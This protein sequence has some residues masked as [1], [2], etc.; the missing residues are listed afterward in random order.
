MTAP[1]RVAIVHERFTDIGGSEKVVEQFHQI[2]P[3][4]VVHA[5]I[6]DRSVLPPGLVDADIRTSSLRRI[7]RGGTS[8]AHLLPLLPLAMRQLDLGPV[9]LVV[10]SHH[11]FANRVR[12]DPS[13]PIVSYVHSP[14]RWLWDARFRAMEAGNRV[15]RLALDAFA[16][17]QRRFDHAAAQRVHTLIANSTHVAN[18]IER[19]W[20]RTSHVVAPPIDTD[21]FHADPTIEREEFFLAAGRLVQYKAVDVAAAAARAAGVRLVVAGDGRAHQAVAAAGGSAVELLG[22]VDGE[23]LRDLFR[24]C[25]ALVFPGE[26]DFGMIPVEAMACGAPVIALGRGGILDSVIDGHTGVHVAEPTASAFAE[27]LRSFDPAAFDAGAIA[28]H[29]RTFGA[30]RFRREIAAIADEVLDG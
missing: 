18:R 14:A 30:D 5:P 10:A 15:E 2:W 3:E 8:Y 1:A 23:T 17:T 21:F 4:A 28:A 11:A 13:I 16:A 12:P 25:R 7:Y 9:D 26:E 19:Y 22:S 27:A 29:G 6:A 20:G 24:R